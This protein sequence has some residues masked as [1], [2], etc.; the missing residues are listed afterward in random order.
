MAET[1]AAGGQTT[2]TTSTTTRQPDNETD[3]AVTAK[4]YKQRLYLVT[5]FLAHVMKSYKTEDLNVK[6]VQHTVLEYSYEQKKT[7]KKLK[8]QNAKLQVKIEV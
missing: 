1:H 7:K 4:F 8:M 6:V 2:T 3:A 5:F